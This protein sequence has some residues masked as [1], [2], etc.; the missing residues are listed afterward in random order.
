MQCSNLGKFRTTPENRRKIVFFFQ[1]KW[2]PASENSFSSKQVLKF[3]RKFVYNWQMKCGAST[4][5]T[6]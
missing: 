3:Y 1:V 4:E 5:I 2:K 6:T